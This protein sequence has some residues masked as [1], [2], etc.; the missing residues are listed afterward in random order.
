MCSLPFN[1]L[2]RAAELEGVVSV[3]AGAHTERERA[4]TKEKKLQKQ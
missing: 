4:R 1:F 3:A 2:P